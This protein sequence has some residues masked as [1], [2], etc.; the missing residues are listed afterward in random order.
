[1]DGEAGAQSTALSGPRLVSQEALSESFLS[2]QA[3]AL[4]SGGT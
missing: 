2:S 1:M 3:C 4:S